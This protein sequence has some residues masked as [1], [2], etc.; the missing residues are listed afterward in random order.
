MA[1]IG[2]NYDNVGTLSGDRR[3]LIVNLGAGDDAYD[4]SCGDVNDSSE[5]FVDLSG[6][7]GQEFGTISLSVS[8]ALATLQTRLGSGGGIGMLR[9]GGVDQGGRFTASVDLGGTTNQFETEIG[10]VGTAT[11]GFVDIDVT[12]GNVDTGQDFVRARLN[13]S[14]GNGTLQ[15]AVSLNANLQ[16]G[17][18]N[19]TLF[20]H[21]DTFNVAAGE[22]VSTSAPRAETAAIAS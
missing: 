13:G 5:L 16:A 18:D 12:G 1:T 3:M 6:G 7:H 10:D 17:G 19:F 14:I 9:V 8:N 20:N 4:L 21:L 15:S 22:S 2:F 11:Q